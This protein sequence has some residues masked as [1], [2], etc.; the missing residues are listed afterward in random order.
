M[1][2]KDVPVLALAAEHRAEARAHRRTLV[3]GLLGIVGF[4]V[5]YLVPYVGLQG[6][7]GGLARAHEDLEAEFERSG[8]RLAA[9]DEARLLVVAYQDDLSRRSAELAE[10]A[11]GSM[12]D[13][14]ELLWGAGNPELWQERQFANLPQEREQVQV[15]LPTQAVAANTPLLGFNQADVL[16]TWDPRL[17]LR[18]VYGLDDRGID[19]LLQGPAADRDDWQHVVDDVLARVMGEAKVELREHAVAGAE[20][21]A[22]DLDALGVEF[23]GADQLARSAVSDAPAKPPVASPRTTGGKDAIMAAEFA[24]IRVPAEDLEHSIGLQVEDLAAAAG[25]LAQRR[26]ELGVRLVAIA[27]EKAELEVAMESTAEQLEDFALPFGVLE[28]N[29][30]RL[31]RWFPLLAALTLLWFAASGARL[32]QRRAVLG[33]MMRE[34]S[35]PDRALLCGSR[36]HAPH[37]AALLACAAFVVWLQFRTGADSDT[38]LLTAVAGAAVLVAVV[39]VRPLLA[40]PGGRPGG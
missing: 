21:L 22:L 37:A 16:D 18:A 36:S 20:Q 24:E 11:K 28:W 1:D 25:R 4:G 9:L 29:S 32:D 5:V 40:P 2:Q 30:A 10:E 17:P 3:A 8:D 26:D 34:L 19:V 7:E 14:N 35:E 23:D 39:T 15:H 12:R 38:L 27:A 33:A 31:V 6:E 13:L